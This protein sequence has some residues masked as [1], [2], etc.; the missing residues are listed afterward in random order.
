MYQYIY[1]LGTACVDIDT[2]HIIGD[3]IFVEHW[4]N[5]W[6]ENQGIKVFCEDRLPFYVY[7]FSVFKV[8]SSGVSPK[9]KIF[10]VLSLYF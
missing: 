7:D 10:L 5:E 1:I 4:M 8:Y 2:G 6:L 3:Q 9:W